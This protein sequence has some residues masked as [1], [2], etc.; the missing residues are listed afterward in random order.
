LVNEIEKE[1]IIKK[2][3]RLANDERWRIRESV[4]MAFQRIGER[5]FTNLRDVFTQWMNDASLVEQ[6]AVIAT[7]AHPPI[8]DNDENTRFCLE[9]VEQILEKLL[10]LD[11]SARKNEEF[12]ILKKGLDYSISVFVEKLPI[13]GFTLLKQWTLVDDLDVKR[14]I[15]SNISKNRLIKN[16]P[17]EVREVLGML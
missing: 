6:R 16:F 7:L 10:L 11:S 14:I 1:K 8:L 9:V 13:E 15:K 4:A 17:S 2:L 5:N 3:Q 12:K